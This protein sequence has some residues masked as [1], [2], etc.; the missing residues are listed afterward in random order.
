[1]ELNYHPKWDD[2]SVGRAFMMS[3]W[4][5]F[6]IPDGT[7]AQLGERATEVRK[8][9]GSIPARPIIFLVFS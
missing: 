5:S 9:A 7:I 8:V 2:S 4:A 3:T 6:F 1:M